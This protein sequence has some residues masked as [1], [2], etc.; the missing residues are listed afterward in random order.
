M[1]SAG[2]ITAAGFVNCANLTYNA[3]LTN[4]TGA[5]ISGFYRIYVDVNSDGYFTPASDTL[6]RDTTAFS[7]AAGPGTTTSITGSVPAVNLNQDLFLVVTQTSGQASGASRVFLLP[8][9]ECSPLPVT[10]RSFTA[11]RIN[12]SNVLL[13]WE[14]STEINNSGFAV[15]KNLGSN[16]WQTIAFVQS[17]ANGGNSNS[18][19]NYSYTDLNMNKGITQYRLKQVDI[20]NKAKFSEVRAVR[21]EGQSAKTIIYPNPSRNGSVSVVF[22]SQD[23]RRNVYLMD[24]YGRTLRKWEGISGN[25]MEIRNLNN[26]MYT[27]R[28]VEKETGS[29]SVEKILVNSH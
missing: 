17:Q 28:I 4:N 1:Y 29:Q 8:S 15:Q 14:T 21:G 6:L 2:F 12:R 19:L 20:D 23:G 18:I 11:Q 10:L 25:T 7:I 26:G 13:R 24:S 27:L 9:T 16:I 22:D 5:A 3:T